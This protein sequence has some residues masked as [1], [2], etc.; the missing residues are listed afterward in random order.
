[1]PGISAEK[2]GIET[3]QQLNDSAVDIASPEGVEVLI[4]ADQK[5]LWVNVNGVCV[6]RCCKIKNLEVKTT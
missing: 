4:R 6:L 3:L 2:M 5:V 1:M